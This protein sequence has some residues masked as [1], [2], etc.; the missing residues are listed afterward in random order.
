MWQAGLG[1][2]NTGFLQQYPLMTH[3]SGL[4]IKHTAHGEEKY[5]FENSTITNFLLACILF[6][7]VIVV[8]T[9]S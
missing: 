7:C 1:L 9:W 2:K 8:S 3:T 4:S 6:D 5:I